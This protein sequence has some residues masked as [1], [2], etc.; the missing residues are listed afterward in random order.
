MGHRFPWCDWVADVVVP[1]SRR[2]TSELTSG[3]IQH[4]QTIESIAKQI[5]NRRTSQAGRISLA[6]AIKACADALIAHEY[7]MM[8]D[9]FPKRPQP[10]KPE[11]PPNQSLG[12]RTVPIPTDPKPL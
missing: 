4:A 6:E 5:Y 11:G 10:P 8:G 9:D 2:A 7:A 12:S 3:T 1:F